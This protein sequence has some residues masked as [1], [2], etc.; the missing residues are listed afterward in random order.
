MPGISAKGNYISS[1][2]DYLDNQAIQDQLIQFKSEGQ[3]HVI[4]YLPQIHCVSC[5]WLLENLHK[6]NHGIIQSQIQFEKRRSKS[7][8]PTSKNKLKRS[9]SIIGFCWL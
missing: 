3:H 1:K 4:F 9:G 7:N 5:V 2:Y 8:L 6:I